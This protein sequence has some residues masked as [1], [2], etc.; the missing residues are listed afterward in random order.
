[1]TLGEQ[2]EAA[3]NVPPAIQVFAM[4]QGS[5]VT[6]MLQT[7]ADHRIF[8]LLADGPRPTGDLAAATGLHAPS[9]HRLLRAMT[10]LG[11]VSTRSDGWALTALGEVA[12]DFGHPGWALAAVDELPRVV[13]TGRT[14][15]ELAHGSPVFEYFAGHPEDA[16]MFDHAMPLM[17][18]G[19]PEAVAEAYDFTGIRELV[20]VGGGNGT[21]LAEVLQRHQLVRGVL[22]DLPGTIAR[23]TPALMRLPDR[24]EA[25][26]GDFFDAVPAG[27]DAYVLCHVV[28]DWPEERCLSILRN[29][30]AA[31]PPDGRLLIVETVMPAGDEPH[32]AKLQDM[33]MLAITGGME[34]TEQQYTELLGRAGFRLDRVIPTR[35]PVSVLEARPA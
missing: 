24:C 22:F 28:H 27:A 14:G 35:S 17:T 11:L 1:M 31:M 20:D 9:L 16:A 10:G 12:L 25:V 7:V 3:P 21:L 15:M 34:R 8:E 30:R 4:W 32:P 2:T 19:E 18:A 5:L 13:A 26:G 29:V 33:M 6:R 23:V